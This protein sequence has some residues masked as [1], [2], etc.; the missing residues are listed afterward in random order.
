MLSIISI[1][2]IAVCALT[3]AARIYEKKKIDLISGICAA[4]CVG[5]A[6]GMLIYHFM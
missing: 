1:V 6:V 4:A 5:A 3:C 2:L